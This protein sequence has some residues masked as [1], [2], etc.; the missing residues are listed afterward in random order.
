[1]TRSIP[2]ALASGID[3]NR[4]MDTKTARKERKHEIRRVVF[5][6]AY[7]VSGKSTERHWAHFVDG[8][9]RQTFTR[10]SYDSCARAIARGWR[11]PI[12]EITKGP[13]THEVIGGGE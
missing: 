1:M 2:L 5:T 9:R 12:G 6:Y 8:I 7:K 4:G 11:V 10:G 3:Y 13:T